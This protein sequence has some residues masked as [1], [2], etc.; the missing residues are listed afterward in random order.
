[1][2]VASDPVRRPHWQ[3]LLLAGLLLI[4]ARAAGLVLHFMSRDPNGNALSSS[5]GQSLLIALPYHGA[6]VLS[7]VGILLGLWKLLPSLRTALTAVGVPLC[8][9]LIVVG[10]VDLGM[11]WFIGQR[12]S[13][14]IFRTYVGGNLLSSDLYQPVLHHLGYFITA[15]LLMV[16]P[17][18]LLGLN[19][20]RG[21]RGAR[22]REATWSG[23]ATIA[24]LALLCRIPIQLAHGHQR[25]VLRPSELLFAYHWLYPSETPPLGDEARAIAE[26]RRLVDPRDQSVWLDPDLPL[27]RAAAAAGNR[28]LT[29]PP[30]EAP[31]IFLFC[32]ESLRG[33][34]VGFI[35]GNYPPGAPTPTPRLDALAQ[36]GV[37]FARHLANGNPSPRGFFCLNAGVWDHRSSF[38]TSGATATEFD[39]LPARL[40]GRGYFTLGLWGADPS[41]DNQLFWARK[42]FDHI[43]YAEPA[44]RFVIMRPLGDDLI[45][46]RLMEE[47]ATHDRERPT[48]P[49]YAYIASAG[50]H[51]P[52]VLGGETRLPAA[53]IAAVAA[54]R[55]TRARYRLVLRELDAQIGR[56]LDFLAARKSSR[57]CVLIITGDHSDL[58]GD[59]VPPEMRDMPHDASE[60]TGALIV[61]PPALIGPVP[62][63]ETYP[64]SHVDFMPT[65]LEFAGD[66]GPV[67]FMGTNLFAD[68][69]IAERTAL[70]ISGRGY[71]LDRAGW[72]LFVMRDHADSFWTKPVGTPLGDLRAGIE[73]SSFTGDDVR[74]L[75]AGIDTWSWLVEHNRVWRNPAATPPASGPGPATR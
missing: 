34:D 71:R 61:G 35:P 47:V 65:L 28:Y 1:M 54:E 52:Y 57:P 23:L 59:R 24:A 29:T 70:S 72:S 74:R 19:F 66:R 73:G 64:T 43:R 22:S 3:P 58:A 7:V 30:P 38:L 37:V 15:L 48:Q 21:R 6:F 44:G 10:Q 63:V 50:T 49:I 56:V 12:F 36:R 18:L 62:R 14:M 68:I 51:E 8:L 25:D 5:P 75:R 20:L 9:A 53:T 41:F 4:V 60:W 13:P 33:A 32:I 17:I 16:G 42:W 11:Q 39:A 40:R 26:L 46:D 55:D 67:V 2:K 69:P 27:V 45:M 31:D